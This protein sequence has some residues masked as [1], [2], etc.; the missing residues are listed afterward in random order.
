MCAGT[1]CPASAQ[2]GLVSANEQSSAF[3][4]SIKSMYLDERGK[5]QTGADM[6]GWNSLTSSCI[7]E[8]H[9][10]AK[11]RDIYVVIIALL[12]LVFLCAGAVVASLVE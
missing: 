3:R 1:V 8:N 7:K 2:G 9:E 4:G 10:V 6:A 12:A 5:K 11:I